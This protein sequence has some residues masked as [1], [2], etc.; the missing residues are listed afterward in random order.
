MSIRNGVPLSTATLPLLDRTNLSMERK[1]PRTIRWDDRYQTE[2]YVFGTEPNDFLVEVADRISSGTVL[3]LADGEG[4]NGVFLASKGHDVTSVDASGVALN[5][6]KQLAEKRGVEM[7]LVK[8]D[9]GDYDLGIEAWDCCVSIFFHMP[10]EM[11]RAMHHRVAQ[12]IRPGGYLVLEAYTP[13]QL[14]FG[15]GGPPV[16]EMLQTLEL[17]REDFAGMEFIIA[18]EVEREVHEG[19]G[20]TGRGAVVQLLARKP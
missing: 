12:S 3:C 1:A 17:L 5:K 8:A 19:K 4:R 11:R 14:G 10:P 7:T 9:L 6:A 15:T 18:R 16:V 2:E 13:A 20:H